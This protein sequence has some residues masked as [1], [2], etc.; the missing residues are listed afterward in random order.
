MLLELL[1]DHDLR[2]PINT[3]SPKP[4]CKDWQ[5]RKV[6]APGYSG[7]IE[8]V[9]LI[10]FRDQGDVLSIRVINHSETPGIGDFIDDQKNPWIKNLD[11]KTEQQWLDIDLVSGATITSKAI[12]TIAT[13]SF[14]LGG[15]QCDLYE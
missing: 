14:S 12:K 13:R 3:A 2:R 15:G 5:I 11:S 9:G 4:E 8:A 6:K 1:S 10:Q 7:S